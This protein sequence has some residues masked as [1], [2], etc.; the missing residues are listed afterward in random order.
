MLAEDEPDLM[1]IFSLKL[2]TSGFNLLTAG[3][4]QTVLDLVKK[5]KPTL[6]L[7]DLVMPDMDGYAVLAELKKDKNLKGKTLVYVWSNLTQKSEIDKAHKLGA[8]G[9]LIK[10]SF[11]PSKLAEK[12]TEILTSIKK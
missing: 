6:V 2:K 8:D 12:V 1:E 3:N 9:Y 5:E 4:G 11:T 7:L 10:S